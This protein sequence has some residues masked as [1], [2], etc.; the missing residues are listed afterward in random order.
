MKKKIIS[1]LVCIALIAALPFAIMGCSADKDVLK[2]ITELE[3]KINDLTKEPAVKNYLGIAFFD[4]DEGDWGMSVGY[5]YYFFA[6]E[7][8]VFTMN[9]I[10]YT[11][12]DEEEVSVEATIVFD[13]TQLYY[14]EDENEQFLTLIENHGVRYYELKFNE[15]LSIN[16]GDCGFELADLGDTSTFILWASDAAISFHIEDNSGSAYSITAIR[17]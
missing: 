9:Y 2:R 3:D 10:G 15:D 17:V 12:V 1:L 4:E 5:G 13:M 16:A 7:G 8:D 11:I 14:W 6:I